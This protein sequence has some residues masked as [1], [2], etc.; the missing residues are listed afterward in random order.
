MPSVRIED[1][2][3]QLLYEAM[4]ADSGRQAILPLDQIPLALQQATIATEDRSFYDNPGV[5][6]VGIVRALWIWRFP[7]SALPWQTSG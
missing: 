1:R 3:G 4:A 6:L 7:V 5:D 2:H